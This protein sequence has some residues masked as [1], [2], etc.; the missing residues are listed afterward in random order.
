MATYLNGAAI[1]PFPQASGTINATNGAV[2]MPMPQAAGTLGLAILLVGAAATPFPT[3][4]GKLN[5]Y[6]VGQVTAPFPRVNTA[7]LILP[8]VFEGAATVPF[9][10]A[11]G[12][13]GGLYGAVIMPF[14]KAAGILAASIPVLGGVAIA[15]F[16]TAAGV[17]GITPSSTFTVLVMNLRNRAVSRYTDYNFNSLCFF[18][19]K[20]LGAAADGI[21]LLEGSLDVNTPIDTMVDI[22]YRDFGPSDEE[23]HKRVTDFYLDLRGDGALELRVTPDEGAEVIYP[24]AAPPSGRLETIRRKLAR[25]EKGRHWRFSIKNVDGSD[26]ELQRIE[27][28]VEVL[29]RRL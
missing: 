26:F 3:A 11:S 25:G 2:T 15:P 14:P 18:N 12:K 27:A 7:G 9:P 17:F 4:S 23:K 28:L 13:L 20:Y 5:Q 19:G 22:G 24:V 1:A 10:K 8:A 29:A 6:F 21:C 16:P